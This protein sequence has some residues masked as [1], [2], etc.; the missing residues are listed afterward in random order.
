MDWLTEPLGSGILRRAMLEAVLTGAACGALGCFVLVRG[1]AFLGEGLAH[2]LLLGVALAF[3][4]GLPVGLPAAVVAALT[5]LLTGRLAA[6]PRLGPDVA[7]GV[8]LPALFGAGVLVAATADG[9]RGRLE[10]A[11]FGSILGTTT[12]DLV[13]AGAVALGTAALL[14]FAGKELVLASFDRGAAEA[15][16]YRVR[17]LDALLLVAVG[18]AVVVGLRAVGN[19]L[20]AALLLGPPVTARLLVRTFA[21][22]AALAAALGAGAGVIGLYVTWHAEVGAGPAI[23]LVITCAFL[24]A[25]LLSRAHENRSR[26]VLGGGGAPPRG[27]R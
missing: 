19:V 2:T 20:L 22:M 9:Y 6:D 25:A 21:P 16:G 1:L 5:V 24:G 4:L 15:M 23:V 10:D 7:M 12:G 11:L 17:L 26:F 18:A 8:L 3:V 13:A 27:V 14:A